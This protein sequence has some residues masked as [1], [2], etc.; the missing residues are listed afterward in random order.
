[1]PDIFVPWD[2]TIVT[3]YYTDIVRKRVLNDFV[4]NYMDENRDKLSKKYS[5][6]PDFIKHF[7]IDKKF[8]TDFVDFAKEKGVEAKNDDY[9]KS[10]QFL[11]TQIKALIARNIWDSSAYFEV[12]YKIDDEFIKAVEILQDDSLYKKITNN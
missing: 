8:M 9:I 10:E 11:K 7:Q 12:I 5:E 6:L 1:M 2:S 3:D 4:M